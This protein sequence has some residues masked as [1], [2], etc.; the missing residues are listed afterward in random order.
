MRAFYKE[1]KWFH[2][3]RYF[4]NFIKWKCIFLWYSEYFCEMTKTFGKILWG[5]NNWQPEEMNPIDTALGLHTLW[6]PLQHTLQPEFT[7]QSASAV[8]HFLMLLIKTHR[9]TLEADRGGGRTRSRWPSGLNLQETFVPNLRGKKKARTTDTAFFA[10]C[11]AGD[12]GRNK[13]GSS[14]ICTRR[15]HWQMVCNFEQRRVPSLFLAIML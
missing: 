15:I 1:L 8:L 7:V 3:S 10:T 5:K 6:V 13:Q 14:M 11:Y 2:G 4:D 9:R 12:R